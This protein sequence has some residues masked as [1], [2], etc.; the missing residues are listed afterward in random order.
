M[1][2]A[3]GPHVARTAP[4]LPAGSEPGRPRTRTHRALPHGLLRRPGGRGSRSMHR[5]STP[6]E[7]GPST[8]TTGQP[9]R[10]DVSSDVEASG[11]GSG[12]PAA[13]K[14]PPRAKRE[15]P[16]GRLTEREPQGFSLFEEDTLAEAWSRG[17]WLL[18][19]L[20]LQSSSSF[21]L[22]SYEGLV[23]EHLVVTLFLTMLV[24]AG[25]NAGNQSAI[26]VIRQLA[27]REIRPTMR[28]AVATILKQVRVGLLLGA[29]LSAGGFVRVFVTQGS[30]VDAAAISSS[31]FLIVLASVVLGSTLPFALAKAGLDPIH[32]GS[33]IQVIM[34]V[35]GVVITCVMCSAV[36][37]QTAAA[38][39]V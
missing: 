3:C 28:S 25:G 39:G 5:K 24:G 10:V 1:P 30:V 32:A 11:A 13:A 7:N 20:V 31:L 27:T 4:R 2:S 26:Q 29:G 14:R 34:D 35:L 37:G 6:Q 23:R 36:L 15:S 12:K 8:T 9:P 16:G 38:L 21:V 22:E 19:L 18:G 33:T 17:R